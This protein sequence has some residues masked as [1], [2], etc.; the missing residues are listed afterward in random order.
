LKQKIP[1]VSFFFNQFPYIKR[2]PNL[3]RIW[4][5]AML[6]IGEEDTI[7]KLLADLP[8]YIYESKKIREILGL[9]Y[10]RQGQPEK[11]KSFIDGIKTANAENIKG[12]IRQKNKEFELA[13]GH[14]QL[15]L[16]QKENSMNALER[17][18][19]LAWHLG[20]WEKGISLLNRL[21]DQHTDQRNKLALNTAF[22][23]R[24]GFMNVAQRQLSLLFQ[25][26]RG[27][28]P[29]QVEVMRSYVALYKEDIQVMN[30]SLNSS[31]DRF[32]LMSC[33]LQMQTLVWQEYPKV[34][35][36]TGKFED[37]LEDFSLANL[38]KRVVKE[39]LEETVV[40]DQRDIEELDGIE[41]KLK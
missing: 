6:Y 12:S 24:Q 40:I 34:I 9:I 4:L 21:V 13:F 8:P 14:Y 15:A 2:D 28:P 19:P 11:A 22:Q 5:K 20:Q 38:K 26:Y 16:K 18:I 35:K 33:W 27:F 7:F 30:Q 29:L 17:A 23:I 31:C 10:Y 1:T 41:V 32:D 39:P 37:G 25:E 36:R 3:V